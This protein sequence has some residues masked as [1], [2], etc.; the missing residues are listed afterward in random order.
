MIMA[1]EFER[2]P[3]LI[4]NMVFEAQSLKHKDTWERKR[5]RMRAV[6]DPES[7]SLPEPATSYGACSTKTKAL[8]RTN[9]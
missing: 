3:S 8:E 6:A 9:S 4:T 7:I 1:E 2:R 5:E